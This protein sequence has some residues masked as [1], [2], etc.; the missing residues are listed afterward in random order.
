MNLFSPRSARTASLAALAAVVGLALSAC[1][2]PS[3]NPEA[4]TDQVQA[5]F[6]AGCTG[7]FTT[8]DGVSTTLASNDVCQCNYAV[9]VYNVPYDDN[10]K[11]QSTYSGYGGQTFLAIN[12]TLKKDP[13]KFNDPTVVPQAVRDKLSQCTKSNGS[14]QTTVKSTGTTLSPN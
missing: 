10:A 14:S 12:D 11:T 7:Q 3:N 13:N 1:T 2:T 4:Y 8:S 9:Y 6:V 5:N